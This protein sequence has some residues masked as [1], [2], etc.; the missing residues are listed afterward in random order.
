MSDNLMKVLIDNF[1]PTFPMLSNTRIM[2]FNVDDNME[3]NPLKHLVYV[4]DDMQ[5]LIEN[6]S[7]NDNSDNITN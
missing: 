7:V 1:N 2:E 4:D 3:H 6:C 5:Y